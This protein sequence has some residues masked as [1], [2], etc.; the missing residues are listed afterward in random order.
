MLFCGILTSSSFIG[1][2]WSS[3]RKKIYPKNIFGTFLLC[4]GDIVAQVKHARK[5]AEKLRPVSRMVELPGGHMITHQHTKEVTI[6]FSP[7]PLDH[8]FIF[9]CSQPQCLELIIEVE[10]INYVLVICMNSVNLSV[11]GFWNRI[12]V[13]GQIFSSIYHTRV[14]CLKQIEM[15]HLFPDEGS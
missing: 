1:F 7:S 9:I 6:N 15:Q 13:S 4:R 14:F 12:L 8:I 2:R 3:W 10:R 11:V 5:I